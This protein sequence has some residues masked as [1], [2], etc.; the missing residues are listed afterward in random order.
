MRKD[1]EAGL[2]LSDA[3]VRH[4]KVF[5]PLFVAMMRAGEIG[6]VLE[7]S[8][9]RVADQLEKEDSLRRQVNSAM[10]YPTVVVVVRGRRDARRSS[11]SSCPCSQASSS[12]SAANCRR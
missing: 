3:L 6:G 2:P 8:L 9:L 12:S 10:V 5:S 7:G 1:V 4:P 11:S